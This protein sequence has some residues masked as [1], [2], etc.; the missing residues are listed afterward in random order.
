M[1][2]R[3]NPLSGRL[4]IGFMLVALGVLWTLDN[5]GLTDAGRIIS[6]WPALVLAVGVMKLTGFGME[7]QAGL[8]TFLTIVGTLLL[9]GKLDFVHI[10]FG[11]LWPLLIIFM[12]T[13][14]VWRA[15]RGRDGFTGGTTDSSDYVRSFSIMSGIARHNQS[16]AFRGGELTAVMGGIQLDLT[17]ALPA[18][19]RAVLD[20]F[21]MWGGIEIRVPEDWRVEIEATPIMGG[22]ESTALVPPGVEPVGTLVV[23]GFAMMGGVEVKNRPLGDPVRVGVVV[24]S[25][26]DG[27]RMSRKEVRIGPGGVTVKREYGGQDP[28]DSPPPPPVDPK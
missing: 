23:R 5:L 22:I 16:Q 1:D 11:I 20:V 4:I 9:L 15:L 7:R 3:A 24:R 8:G 19:G 14:V 2:E 26:R 12:G 10:G 18:D 25:R 13:Q 21:A 28:A 27:E 17:G 6:W